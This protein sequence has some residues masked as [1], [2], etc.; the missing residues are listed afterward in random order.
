[1]VVAGIVSV[2]YGVQ[3][4]DPAPLDMLKKHGVAVVHQE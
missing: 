4:R 2:V 3:Y 1:L